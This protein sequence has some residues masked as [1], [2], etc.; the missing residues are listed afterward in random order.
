MA[1]R[2]GLEPATPRRDR[3]PFYGEN[4]YMTVLSRLEDF[5]SIISPTANFLY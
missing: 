4:P 2:T 3:P 1:E 5:L